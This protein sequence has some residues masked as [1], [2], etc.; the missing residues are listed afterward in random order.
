MPES[1]PPH[2]T[3]DREPSG[4]D[5][6]EADLRDAPAEAKWQAPIADASCA[7]TH[8][9]PSCKGSAALRCWSAQRLPTGS[10]R[11]R[12]K[13]RVTERLTRAIDQLGHQN[14]DVR[15]GCIYA[16]ER[17]AVDSERDRSTIA[18]VLTAFVR[19]HAPW[20]PSQPGQ[21]PRTLRSRI[22]PRC[23]GGRRTFR[24]P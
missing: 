4:P 8:G 19:G 24:P 1:G 15:L 2:E 13:G 6:S 7:T 3:L 12:A 22:S 16:L 21:P 10:S 23:I 20:P 14:L 17:I 11:S 9:Q 18:E 5:A